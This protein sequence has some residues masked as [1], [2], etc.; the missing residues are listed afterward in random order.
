MP[1][2]N[3]GGQGG[4]FV[5]DTERLLLRRDVRN[6]LQAR[7]RGEGLLGEERLLG[8]RRSSW[9]QLRVV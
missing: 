5:F 1:G 8:K 6:M 3:R 7:E 9:R 2:E 4:H